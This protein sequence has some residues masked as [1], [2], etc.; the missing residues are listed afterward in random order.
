M[1]YINEDIL[2]DVKAGEYEIL[3]RVVSSYEDK[4]FQSE[5]VKLNIEGFSLEDLNTMIN[6]RAGEF[7]RSSF[8]DYPLGTV[9]HTNNKIIITKS[10]EDSSLNKEMP[11]KTLSMIMFGLPC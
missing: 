9:A 3:I 1:D 11:P 4:I 8:R 5:D 10:F 2:R 7:I 6:E